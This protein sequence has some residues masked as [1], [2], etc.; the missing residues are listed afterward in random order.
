MGIMR[1][2]KSLVAVLDLFKQS[3]GALSVVELI[4]LFSQKM[5][6]TTV[7]RILE[8]L[9]EDGILHSFMGKDR[10]K[11]YAICNG[12]TSEQHKDAHPH[13]Q[14]KNCGKIKCLSFEVS[15]PLI[16]DIKIDSAE[17][18]LTGQCKDCVA[19]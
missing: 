1:K 7:Y 5:N 9:E 18:F 13:F 19:L 12:C 11:W 16:P 10:L 2:T 4:E 14:C 3:N 17:I 15:I 8:R 6:K